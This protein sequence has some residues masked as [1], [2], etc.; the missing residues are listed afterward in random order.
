[1]TRTS[2]DFTSLHFLPCNF[3]RT[4][5]NQRCCIKD[6][7]HSSYNFCSVVAQNLQSIILQQIQDVQKGKGQ[8]ANEAHPGKRSPFQKAN[9]FSPP[10]PGTAAGLNNNALKNAQQTALTLLLA[11][12]LQN[13]GGNGATSGV[14]GSP[15]SSGSL[16]PNSAQ[17]N[18]QLLSALQ[19][20]TKQGS[21][22]NGGAPS[23]GDHFLNG[24]PVNNG[25]N[26]SS[27]L[28]LASPNMPPISP[29]DNTTNIPHGFFPSPMMLPGVNNC[30]NE[31]QW[32]SFKSSRNN[33]F[34]SNGHHKVKT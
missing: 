26:L 16:S 30:T 6:R 19:A 8:T 2:L 32:S 28:G 11:S 9:T 17:Q 15:G 24:I 21:G 4:R 25:P 31:D 34:G 7:F 22:G 3:L 18:Q 27:L 10:I 14:A 12:Q 20:M 5:N 23:G 13:G 1:M 33:Q 29:A